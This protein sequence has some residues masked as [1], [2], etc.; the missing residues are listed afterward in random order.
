MGAKKGF[1]LFFV[2]KGFIG[3]LMEKTLSNT[4]LIFVP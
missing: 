2:G 3:K 4:S 1:H